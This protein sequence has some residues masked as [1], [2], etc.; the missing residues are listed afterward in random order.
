ML[1]NIASLLAQ[2][3]ATFAN[4]VSGVG[5]LKNAQDAPVL[6]SIFRQRGFA[7]F[8]CALVE[9]PLCRPE[10]LCEAEAVAVLPPATAGG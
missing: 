7:G 9:A 6:R 8:P 3:G 4:L 1:H 2:Q 5:Y 10:L